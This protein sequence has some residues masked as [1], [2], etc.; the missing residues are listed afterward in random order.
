MVG[1][2]PVILEENF[3]TNFVVTEGRLKRELCSTTACLVP[4]STVAKTIVGSLTGESPP[5]PKN[6]GWRLK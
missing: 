6:E 2:I 3:V 1:V 4:S 5:L